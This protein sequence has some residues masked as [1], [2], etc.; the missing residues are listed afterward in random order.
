MCFSME[1]PLII[2]LVHARDPITKGV[3]LKG[4][5]EVP[6]KRQVILVN[7]A[8]QSVMLHCCLFSTGL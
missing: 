2:I 3:Y 5:P 4:L 6:D 1:I 8:F 7:N